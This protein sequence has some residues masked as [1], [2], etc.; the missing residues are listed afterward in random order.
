MLD[1]NDARHHNDHGRTASSEGLRPSPLPQTLCLFL[2]HPGA[3]LVTGTA[4][5]L[6]RAEHAIALDS[7]TVEALRHHRDTQKLEHDQES[8]AD[9]RALAAVEWLVVDPREAGK[10]T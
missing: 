7:E 9:A 4:Q 10:P 2:D 6:S 5:F 8:P 3:H 1:V